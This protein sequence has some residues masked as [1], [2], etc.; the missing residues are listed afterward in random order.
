MHEVQPL[1]L[2]RVGMT[3]NR[4]R[5][6]IHG[7]Q[8]RKAVYTCLHCLTDYTSKTKQCECGSPKIHYFPSMA[9]R[10][11]FARLR[12]LERAGEIE[13]LRL[14]PAFPIVVNHTKV[15]TYKADFEYQTRE[16]KRVIEDVKG[17]ETDVFKL[18]RKLVEAFYGITL[19]IV[20]G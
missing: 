20:K 9:E 11:R 1:R 17:I 6:K 4:F 15:M 10:E 18:K 13:Q 3:A 16:G 2:E 7:M 19:T 8:T 5:S 14:Q 12:F